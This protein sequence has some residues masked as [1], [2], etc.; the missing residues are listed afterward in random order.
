MIDLNN[1]GRNSFW[2]NI[3]WRCESADAE[4]DKDHDR[5]IGMINCHDIKSVAKLT[6]QFDVRL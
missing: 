5:V 6:L 3:T 1:L 2:D 4:N